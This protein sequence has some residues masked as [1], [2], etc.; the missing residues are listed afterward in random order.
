MANPT[1]DEI[2]WYPTVGEEKARL[3]LFG[4]PSA[5]QVVLLCA[6]FPDDTG[7]FSP[8]ARGLAD[9]GCYCGVTCLLGYEDCKELPWQKHRPEGHSFDEWALGVQMAAKT[10]KNKSKNK[11]AKLTG[12]FHDWGSVA[13][14]M[15]AIQA[16]EDPLTKPD[17]VVFFD[18]MPLAVHPS[19]KPV[20]KQ[21]L[22][23]IDHVRLL[24]YRFIFAAAYVLQWKVS[25][26]LAKAYFVFAAIFLNVSQL[27]PGGALD[28]ETI[29][30]NKL[31]LDRLLYMMFPYYRLLVRVFTQ[32]PSN[33]V[34]GWYLPPP[35]VP[36]LFLY[37]TCKNVQFHDANVAK[38]LQT[39]HH[40]QSDCI[41]VAD[42]GH[43]LYL[44]QA[45]K[46]LAAVKAFI[47]A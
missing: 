31:E 44:H 9:A 20:P 10:L 16:L 11:A 39:S 33:V 41:A 29:Q 13:G 32:P 19:M 15:Y 7:S 27:N 22:P 1:P 12:I 3:C 6:G 24:T 43:W 17:K 47:F 4:N 26:F 25:R 21:A 28:D 40:P 34:P 35:S 18:V 36:T 45:E 42:A 14:G 30:A 2:V 23:F 46:C 5:S 8:F 37:G 38:S